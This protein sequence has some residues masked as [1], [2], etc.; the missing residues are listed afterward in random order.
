MTFEIGYFIYYSHNQ[1]LFT[2]IYLISF[3]QD[4]DQIPSFVGI[5]WREEGEGSSSSIRTAC[6]TNAMH[7]VFRI[8]W[9]VEVDNELNVFNIFS[10]CK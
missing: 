1:L 7:I 10:V 6:A 3:S 5:G 4:I 8:R 2:T 9:I